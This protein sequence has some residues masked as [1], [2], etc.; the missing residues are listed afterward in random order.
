MQRS[1]YDAAILGEGS[2][3]Y[4]AGRKN[5]CFE[6]YATWRYGQ[7]DRARFQLIVPIEKNEG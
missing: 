4:A 5:S 7:L 3:G 2:A 6:N 1:D